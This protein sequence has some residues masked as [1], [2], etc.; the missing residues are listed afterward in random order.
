MYK[1]LKTYIQHSDSENEENKDNKPSE[2][3]KPS[4]TLKED[5]DYDYDKEAFLKLKKDKLPKVL[6][7]KE[8]FSLVIPPEIVNYCGLCNKR[9]HK[10]DEALSHFESKRHLKNLRAVTI[11]EISNYKS[12]KEYL[13]SKG[14]IENTKSMKN[15][16]KELLLKIQLANLLKVI[17]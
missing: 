4:L 6:K 16:A 17:N 2:E 1:R 8:D 7:E 14:L 13:F 5:N 10:E 3:I 15:N 12:V 9:T 11:K